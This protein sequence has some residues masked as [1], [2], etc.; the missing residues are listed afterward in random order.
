[1]LADLM[2]SKRK[3]YFEKLS[4]VENMKMCLANVKLEIYSLKQFLDN[5]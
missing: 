1:M 2:K 3:F 4:Y 5:Y